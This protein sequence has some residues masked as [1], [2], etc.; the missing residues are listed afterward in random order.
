M[1]ITKGTL[2]R[3]AWRGARTAHG[4]PAPCTS[5]A[6]SCKVHVQW[7]LFTS[8]PTIPYFVLVTK[9]SL[10]IPGMRR[11]RVEAI[12]QVQSAWRLRQRRGFWSSSNPLHP[13]QMPLWNNRGWKTLPKL[14]LPFLS[15]TPL[16]SAVQQWPSGLL[17]LLRVTFSVGLLWSGKVTATLQHERV[18]LSSIACLDGGL[19]DQ[20]SQALWIAHFS[21][22]S[23]SLDLCING[24][25]NFWGS[26]QV[27]PLYLQTCISKLSTRQY[28]KSVKTPQLYLTSSLEAELVLS[29][30][31]T[32]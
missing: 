4:P 23:N 11:W 9:Y 29:S 27:F 6:G 15:R 10:G 2:S 20:L 22:M 31:G 16:D 3:N 1:P 32:D 14:S 13:L 19:A 25:F 12:C 8:I 17:G 21:R 26:Y 7:T 18:S 28:Q 24:V 5:A 30:Q